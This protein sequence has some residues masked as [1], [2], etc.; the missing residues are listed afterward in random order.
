MFAIIVNLYDVH[1][2]PLLFIIRNSGLAPILL[3]QGISVALNKDEN[4]LCSTV[5]AAVEEKLP[6]RVEIKI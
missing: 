2:K 1:C 5:P 4:L 3:N 6:C